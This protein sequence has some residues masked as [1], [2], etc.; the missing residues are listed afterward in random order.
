MFSRLRQDSK[1]N[2]WIIPEKSLVGSIVGLEEMDLMEGIVVFEVEGVV[3][4]VD[5]SVV[6]GKIVV[7]IGVALE[8]EKVVVVVVESVD[9]GEVVVVTG[10]VEFKQFFPDLYSFGL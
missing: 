7:V 8:G 6:A 1:W 3:V 2:I 4:V 10:E 9:G 5:E